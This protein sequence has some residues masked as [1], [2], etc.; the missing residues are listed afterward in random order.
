MLF[1]ATATVK[2]VMVTTV[3][4]VLVNVPRANAA[5]LDPPKTKSLEENV[6]DLN[7]PP[8]RVIGTEVPPAVEVLNA[9]EVIGLYATAAPATEVT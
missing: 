3:L 4:L 8:V 1:T 7:V 5:A 2:P 6:P 9:A